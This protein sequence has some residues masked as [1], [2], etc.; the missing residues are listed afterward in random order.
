MLKNVK[1]T[2]DIP[3]GHTVISSPPP[4]PNSTVDVRSLYAVELLYQLPIYVQVQVR[5]AS[6]DVL[7]RQLWAVVQFCTE[8]SVGV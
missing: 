1:Y 4:Q 6:R 3:G 5:V 7:S 2:E 8:R